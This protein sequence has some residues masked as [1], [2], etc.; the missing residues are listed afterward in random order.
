MKLEQIMNIRVVR[1]RQMR[2][3]VEEL[4][5]MPSGWGGVEERFDEADV[6]GFDVGRRP[7]C[8]GAE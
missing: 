5:D 7:P 3:A 4:S 2:R 6:V 1:R 8:P